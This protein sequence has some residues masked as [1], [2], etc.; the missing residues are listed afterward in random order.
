[1][2][3][4]SKR[5][6]WAVMVGQAHRLPDPGFKTEAM[7]IARGLCAEIRAKVEIL[8]SE[9]IATGYVFAFPDC[10]HVTNVGDLSEWNEAAD[11]LG[12]HLPVFLQAWIVE[13]G[14]VNLM[15]SHPAWPK[16]A[17]SGIGTNG[18]DVWYT[19]ALVLEVGLE[20]LR[21]EFEDWRLN[22]K[23]YGA[24]EV[25][26]F[27]WG[28]APDYIHKANISGGLPYAID[29]ATPAVDT[30]LLNSPDCTSLFNHVSN[31][32]WW[33]GFPGFR[34]IDATL[35]EIVVKLREKINST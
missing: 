31:A 13:V 10:V 5:T 17:Y 7:T 32:I 25:G 11:H 12:I 26:P 15:G 6:D 21:G 33:G 22:A 9:L 28:L 35:P 14:S 34:Y 3:S 16:S 29:M 30:L 1:M 27:H 18:N 23:E 2:L 19:D 20:H 24:T 8:V 4:P